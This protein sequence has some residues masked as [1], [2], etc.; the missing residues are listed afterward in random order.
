MAASDL[1]ELLSNFSDSNSHKKFSHYY[2][3]AKYINHQS[4]GYFQTFRCITPTST[5]RFHI[6]E[7]TIFSEIAWEVSYS[8]CF[9]KYCII[10]ITLITCIWTDKVLLGKSSLKVESKR[11]NLLQIFRIEKAFD[12]KAWI[13]P[14]EKMPG[15]KHDT[16]KAI[17]MAELVII[18]Y[19]VNRILQKVGLWLKFSRKL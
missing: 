18:V 19:I 14:P 9:L 5:R 11:G 17:Y 15:C 7:Y 3:P 10:L 16:T 13:Y 8:F 6:W 4:P 1:L 12:I 2:A